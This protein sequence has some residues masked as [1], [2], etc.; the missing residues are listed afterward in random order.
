MMAG[1]LPTG[2]GETPVVESFD[3]S[4]GSIA[5]GDSSTLS[6][7]V[8]NATA[9]S[10][11]QGV[12]NVALS[13]TRVVSPSATT[14]YTL[15]ASN[16]AGSATATAQVMVS[17]G[18]EAE[19]EAEAE[20]ESEE[21]AETVSE[22]TVTLHSIPGEDG[23]VRQ[24][25]PG[26]FT[27]DVIVGDDQ[28]NKARQAFL[29]FDISGI[30]A[31]ASIESASLN[32]NS[33]DKL[34]IPFTNLGK[35]RVYNDQYGT[36]GPGDFTSGF[37]GGAMTTYSLSSPPTGPLSNSALISKLQTRVDAG[38]SRFQVRLQFEKQ[39]DWNGKIDAL[40]LTSPKLVVTYED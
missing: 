15:T 38:N 8:S 28:H 5:S 29:S 10:I 18:S 16:D 37:P 40:R 34:G 2:G 27:D 31:G 6:W 7:S 19:S 26:P 9:V 12:G 25:A 30:P 39:T 11:D 3:A 21:E 20:T 32:V 35:L 4:P 22:H 13:G 1:C 23:N 17:S 33:F 14:T 24:G 36:L